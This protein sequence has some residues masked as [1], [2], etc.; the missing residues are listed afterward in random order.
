MGI[1]GGKIGGRKGGRISGPRTIRIIHARNGV[2]HIAPTPAH[3]AARYGFLRQADYVAACFWGNRRTDARNACDHAL[4][5]ECATRSSSYGSRKITGTTKRDT[6][7]DRDPAELEDWGTYD[8]HAHGKQLWAEY[9][10][11]VQAAAV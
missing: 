1:E 8:T 9:E 11:L 5:A 4:A 6:Y 10:A 3:A 2:R 7:P